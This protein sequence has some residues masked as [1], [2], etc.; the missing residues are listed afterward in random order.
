VS[1]AKGTPM[2]RNVNWPSTREAIT[3][4][5]CETNLATHATHIAE[6]D[7]TRNRYY[8]VKCHGGN[9]AAA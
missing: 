4:T 9:G 8:C 7:G 5:A 6:W 3:C 2:P 1:A